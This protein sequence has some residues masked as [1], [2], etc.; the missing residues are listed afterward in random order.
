VQHTFE[1]GACASACGG[2]NGLGKTTLLKIIMGDIEPT[3]GT[4]KIGQLHEI[5]YVDQGALKLREDKTV[6][7]EISDGT[8][9]VV[10]GE[11]KLSP[12]H[13]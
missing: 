2:R 12:A 9:F 8:E 11:G 10:F 7:E 4:V 5:Y 3:E 6:F 13:T 1:A